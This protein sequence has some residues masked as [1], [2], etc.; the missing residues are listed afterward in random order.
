VENDQYTLVPGGTF[1]EPVR[2][3]NREKLTVFRR[4]PCLRWIHPKRNN[5][6]HTEIVIFSP[7]QR[8]TL[9]KGGLQEEQEEEQEEEE[10]EEKGFKVVIPGLRAGIQQPRTVEPKSQQVDPVFQYLPSKSDSENEPEPPESPPHFTSF[11]PQTPSPDLPYYK[12]PSFMFP[13]PAPPPSAVKPQEPQKPLNNFPFPAVPIPPNSFSGI[14]D[15]IESTSEVPILPLDILRIPPRS[16]PSSLRGSL[17]DTSKVIL[18]APEV[19]EVEEEDNE[20]AK[21]ALVE[22]AGR[23]VKHSKILFC[24]RFWKAFA[25]QQ[26]KVFKVNS[27]FFATFSPLISNKRELQTTRIARRLLN[28]LR[29]LELRLLK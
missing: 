27:L 1:T 15:E 22:A 10:E 3:D 26:R 9:E 20:E 8:R 18:P 13:P 4:K 5:F 2:E 24:V 29:L 28:R 23:F 21:Q 11:L 17:E 14:M 7:N 16:Q 6:S 12:R 25:A 19:V